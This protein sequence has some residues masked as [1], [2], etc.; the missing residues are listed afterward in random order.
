MT[1]I[2]VRLD[3]SV[4]GFCVCLGWGAVGVCVTFKGG[5]LLGFVKGGR[6]FFRRGVGGALRGC[7]RVFLCLVMLGRV[8]VGFVA[9]RGWFCSG[10]LGA[11]ISK[12]RGKASVCGFQGPGAPV[13]F[14]EVKK[15]MPTQMPIRF[16]A[17]GLGRCLQHGKATVIH[18][19]SCLQSGPGRLCVGV[20]WGSG[21]CFAI[22]VRGRVSA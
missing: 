21:G 3:D 13:L 6:R 4:V 10:A 11:W 15:P 5:G 2:F 7:S 12:W 17:G 18:R 19:Y 16:C 8:V 14:G 22:R 9:G 1:R 20:A